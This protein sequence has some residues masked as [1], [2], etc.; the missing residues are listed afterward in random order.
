MHVVRHNRPCNEFVAAAV[1]MLECI[2]D[3][4]C[5]FWIGE[6]AIAEGRILSSVYDLLV[7]GADFRA[8]FQKFGEMAA[9]GGA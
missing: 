1:K 8:D 4:S 7:E 5:D 6:M 9:G 3:Q 2:F